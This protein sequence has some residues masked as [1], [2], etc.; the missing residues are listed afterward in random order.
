MHKLTTFFPEIG[1]GMG[2]L[3]KDLLQKEILSKKGFCIQIYNFIYTSKRIKF[4]EFY[5]LA[6]IYKAPA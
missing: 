4:G 2:P 5:E 3:M 1:R 6:H